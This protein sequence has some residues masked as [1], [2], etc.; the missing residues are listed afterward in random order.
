MIV[1]NPIYRDK[2]HFLENRFVT[3]QNNP[4]NLNLQLQLNLYPPWPIS[5]RCRF[6]PIPPHPDLLCLSPIHQDVC[7]S[8]LTVPLYSDLMLLHAAC[9]APSYAVPLYNACCWSVP[10]CPALPHSTMPGTAPCHPCCSVPLH[11]AHSRSVL[12][13]AA[14]QH[15][16]LPRQYWGIYPRFWHHGWTRTKPGYI[17]LPLHLILMYSP[18]HHIRHLNYGTKKLIPPYQDWLRNKKFLFI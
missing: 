18:L 15:Q 17:T 7:L 13:G 4:K 8:F 9:T 12:L 5:G 1:S 16:N 14:L 2:P 11:V 3:T 10:L 6:H